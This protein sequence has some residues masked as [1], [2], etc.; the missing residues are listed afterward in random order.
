M[1]LTATFCCCWGIST[2]LVSGCV[3]DALFKGGW[4]QH[5]LME[6]AS[7]AARYVVENGHRCCAYVGSDLHFK[8]AFTTE[9][10]AH[11]WNCAMR[12]RKR[13]RGGDDT[14]AVRISGRPLAD[15]EIGAFVGPD[16]YNP[17]DTRSANTAW[18]FAE[19]PGAFDPTHACSPGNAWD[20]WGSV[21][22]DARTVS[23]VQ[24]CV[25]MLRCWRMLT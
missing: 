7:A 22:S 2:D 19:A 25:F 12:P 3:K 21:D 10:E 14:I 1:Q 20:A 23:R 6:A 11:M 16:D 9:Q 15:V 17:A 8:F 4:R 5:L 18:G 24:H 13:R